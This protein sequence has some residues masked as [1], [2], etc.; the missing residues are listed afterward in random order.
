MDE[1]ETNSEEVE[2]IYLDDDDNI[3]SEMLEE[4]PF[5]DD[6]DPAD[7]EDF[8][9]LTFIKHSQSVFCGDLT[10][11]SQLAVTG[12][13]DDIAY[14]WSPSTGEVKFECT[15]H[16]DSVIAACFN[17]DSQLLATGDMSGMIQVWNIKE[18]KLIWCYEG[19]DLEWMIWHPC[20]NVLISGMQSG[21]IFVWQIPQ[22][23]CRML[24]SHGS[25]CTSGKLL[26]DGK[27]ILAGYA[28]GV[29]KLWDIKSTTAK[30]QLLDSAKPDI[31]SLELNSSGT[32]CSV[33]PSSSLINVASG[34]LVGVLLAE[35]ENEIEA[36]VFS[37]ELN[38]LVTGALSG[39][40]CVWDV[41][42]HVI[43]HQAKL[44]CGI[45]VLK[46]GLN[47]SVFIGSTDGPIY[48]CDIRSGSYLDTL[49]GHISNVLSLCF[50]N[51]GGF[52]LSTSD[53]K[54]AKVFAI[55]EI[56]KKNVQQ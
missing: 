26:P 41:A 45:T 25:S 17:H 51:D 3:P 54:T 6:S 12:G 42:K 35:G 34:K 53:D 33:A 16:K 18:N 36:H 23:N 7:Y 32:L 40:V 5:E 48:V 14:V 21:E 29:I 2:V 9:K 52:V 1:D 56:I 28:D 13:E 44:D 24:M 4:E 31:T 8:A 10:K 38:L 27:Q 19:D 37:S 20:A 43:R 30:W 47:G 39:Q 49:K 46:L 15:G 50:S 55:N 11:D 22:G